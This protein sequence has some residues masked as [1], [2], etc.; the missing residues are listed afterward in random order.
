M[1]KDMTFAELYDHLSL[2]ID[3]PEQRWKYVMRVKRTMTDCNGCGGNGN[4]QCYFT[5]KKGIPS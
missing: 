4:D 3:D 1:A 5:G 2:Y